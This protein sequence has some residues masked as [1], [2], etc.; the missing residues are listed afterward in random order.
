MINKYFLS[1]LDFVTKKS[2]RT[3]RPSVHFGELPEVDM[4]AL[5]QSKAHIMHPTTLCGTKQLHHGIILKP[6][7]LLEGSLLW[8]PVAIVSLHP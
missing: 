4:D 6:E 5:L 1:L 7:S 3:H 8:G 2:C